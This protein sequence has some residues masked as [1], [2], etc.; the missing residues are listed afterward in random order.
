[1]TSSHANKPLKIAVVTG[2]RAE[3]GLLEPVMRAIDDHPGL[4][5]RV[6]A[7]GWH[8]VAKTTR[9]ITRAGFALHAK[10]PMQI[11]GQ[12]GYDAD[13]RALGRGVTGLTKAFESLR[14]DTVLVL[15]DRIE[16]FA[17]A[18][19]AAVGGIRVC[20]IHGG[21]RAEGVAD[22]S[23]RHA[24][25]KLA[26]LHFAATAQSRRRLIRMGE[27]PATVFNTGSP[28]ADGLQSVQPFDRAPTLIVMQH[29][30]GDDD[31]TER[32]RMA[33]TLRAAKK[34]GPMVMAPNGD[35]GR[36]GVVRAIEEA[37]CEMI[38]NM[39]RAV[40]LGV[41]AGAGA[42]G[43]AIVGNSSAALIEASVLRV[44]A[45]NIGPR[46]NGREKPRNVI[47]C[48][49]GLNNVRAA[50][51]KALALDTRRLRHPYGAGC[52]G[53]TIAGVLASGALRQVKRRK[54]N[55]Y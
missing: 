4:K 42:S 22:E 46:Q 18:S 55:S 34:H 29:P 25:S 38:T 11:A 9:D 14:P 51:K 41:L 33:A 28:A 45:V 32:K 1:M 24:I 5:L 8:F 30:I 12:T 35:P 53:V 3:F 44:P 39:P 26:H 47:D 7:A 2:T 54:R 48:D 49:Y 36:D 27:D 21:D 23:M 50:I 31:A 15:G 40:W 17:A 6:V 20:H 10:V 43:G 52:A 37:G 16:A 19:A 13:A